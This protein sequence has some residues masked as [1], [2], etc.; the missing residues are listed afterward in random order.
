MFRAPWGFGMDL[1]WFFPPAHSYA[2]FGT[3][4]AQLPY[5]GSLGQ[6]SQCLLIFALEL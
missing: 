1:R 4:C 6:T 5:I 3:L 2:S